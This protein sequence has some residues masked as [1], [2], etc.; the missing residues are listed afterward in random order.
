MGSV[1]DRRS[2][3]AW[4][5]TFGYAFVAVALTKNII[6]VPVYLNYISIG[7]YGAWLATG[8]ILAQIF[9]TDFGLGAVVTQKVSRLMGAGLSENTG[10]TIT[11]GILCSFIVAFVVAIV[12]VILSPFLVGL[13][14]IEDVVYERI[15]ACFILAIIANCISIL[16][17]TSSGVL[18][19]LHRPVMSGATILVADIVNIFFTILLL[20]KGY[21]LYSLAYGMLARGIVLMSGGLVTVCVTVKTSRIPFIGPA[22]E[23]AIELFRNSFFMLMTTLMMRLQTR[24]DVFFIGWLISPTVAAI[25]SISTRVYETIILF[26]SQIGGASQA[27]LAN[28]YGTPYRHRFFGIILKI[29]KIM[30]F[31][32]A[33]TLSGYAILNEAFVSLWVGNE[34]YAGDSVILLIA[35]TGYTSAMGYV[36]YDALVSMGRF[37]FISLVYS[38]TGVVY[39]LV[40]Y[41]LLQIDLTGAPLAVLVSSILWGAV[42]WFHLIR[43]AEP[44]WGVKTI[45]KNNFSLFLLYGVAVTLAGI[46]IV[47]EVGSWTV[48]I[49]ACVSCILVYLIITTMTSRSLRSMLVEEYMVTTG[50]Q[51]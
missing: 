7:E 38:V 12:L 16:G 42:F 49:V 14:K 28:L 31:V 24:S 22:V 19:S 23:E 36:A 3:A 30:L 11:T 40:I 50:R 27:S 10:R 33:G 15:Y 46:G 43:Y 44:D 37:R 4:N 21:G 35:L 51:R 1:T 9:V 26:I 5:L 41:N 8:G 13:M 6:L 45:S 48:F 17:L 39:L 18:K 29:Q 32:T 20:I 25:Y 47:P 34:Y 2:T